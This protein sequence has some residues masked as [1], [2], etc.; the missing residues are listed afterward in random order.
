MLAPTGTGNSASTSRPRQ[1][2]PAWIA[3][4]DG[5][6]PWTRLMGTNDVY[7]FTLAAPTGGV[8]WVTTSGSSTALQVRHLTRAEAS[9]APIVFC[10]ALAVG[11]KIVTGTTAGIVGGQS[12]AI[13]LGGAFTSALSLLPTFV[14]PGIPAG[15]HDL[16]A[17][18][19]GSP[20]STA[21]RVILRRDQDPTNATALATLDFGGAEAFAPATA[22][23]TL[24]GLAAGEG[25]SHTMSYLTGSSC[26]AAL[27]YTTTALAATHAAF[28]VPEARQRPTDYH[29]LRLD[30][31]TT[32]T[33][34]SVSTSF[35]T[36]APRTV[37]LG[38]A[39]G[40]PTITTLAGAYL[41]LQASLAVPAEY[42]AGASLYYIKT[43]PGAPQSVTVSATPGYAGGT[44]AALVTPDLSGV[45]GWSDS[46]A[47]PP[48]SAVRWTITAA[49][50]SGAATACAEGARTITA[51]VQ[52]QR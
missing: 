17:Y 43:A 4:Q 23:V 10:P 39:L 47:P 16:V 27:L 6:A 20:P 49:G 13:T 26:D 31:V 3:Y 5:A 40:T 35:H 46:W 37:T 12:A 36:L 30:A 34:R 32:T 41:R 42:G 33:S 14:L 48:G 24:A 19:Q 7:A 21:D 8:A 9:A 28:G 25:I 45:T 52:G 29:L 38:A 2:R 22:A 44:A 51:A 1:C 11:T 15:P 50:G 18:R